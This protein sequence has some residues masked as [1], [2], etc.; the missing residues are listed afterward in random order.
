MYDIDAVL[1]DDAD[2]SQ[3]PSKLSLGHLVVEYGYD[4]RII[5]GIAL[6]FSQKLS[7]ISPRF[8]KLSVECRLSSFV[9]PSKEGITAK[10]KESVNAVKLFLVG[11]SQLFGKGAAY[12][13]TVVLSFEGIGESP[14]VA[15]L[16]L[17]EGALMDE[18]GPGVGFDEC[19][20]SVVRRSRVR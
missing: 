5:R 18:F 13:P 9:A 11:Q 3:P 12:R 6:E 15:F 4:R 16:D 20:Y 14:D 17:E 7:S 10:R 2:T 8:E 19:G 1:V